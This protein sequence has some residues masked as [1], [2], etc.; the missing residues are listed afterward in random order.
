MPITK[1]TVDQL[2]LTVDPDTLG[3]ADTSELLHHPLSWIGQERAE[4]AVRFGLGMDQADYNLFVLGEAGSGR[5]SLL[6]QAMQVAASNRATPPDLC[7]LYNFDAPERPRALRLPSGQGRLL[8]QHMARMMNTLLADIPQQLDGPHF[9]V[10]SER[11]AKSYKEEESRAYAELDAFGEAR[12][13]TMHRESGHLLFTLRGREGHAMTEDEMLA[14]PKEQRAE[15]DRAEQELI[16]EINRYMELTRPLERVMVDSLASL[17]RKEVKPLL[18][19]EL[20]RIRTALNK[21]NQDSARLDTYLHQVKDDIL[22]NLELFKAAE[23]DDELRKEMLNKLLTRYRINLVVDNDG[24][25]GA[26][27]IVEDNPLFRSLFGSIEY[28]SEN[29]VLVTDFSRIR[30]GSLHRADGGFLMLHLRDLLADGL[31]WEKLRRFLRSGRLQIEEPGTAFAPIAA[32][33]L[34]PEA[35]DVD[36]KIILIG[37]RDLYYEL[38][39]GDPEFARRFRVKVDFAERFAASDATRRASA[40]FVAHT[41]KLLGLPHFS[42]AAVSRLLEQGH[43]EAEDKS[44]Q[45]AIF[46]HTEALILESAALCQTRAG[47]LVAAVDVDMALAARRQRH[48]YPEQRLRES[49]AEGDVLIALQGESVGQLN[50]LTVV[51]LGDHRFGFPVRVSARTYAGEEGLINIEREV[52]MSGPIHDKGVLILHHY[53]AALFT[54]NAPL[55]FNASIVFEQEY[56]GVEGD[57]ASCAELYVL[58]SSLSGLPLRQGI[59]VTGALNQHGEV[60]PVGGINEKIEGFFDICAAAGLEGGQGVLIPDRN[61]RHLMLDHRVVEAVAQGRFHIHTIGHVIDGLE[62]LAGVPAGRV[63]VKGVY[64]RG[65][66]LGLAQSTLQ[67]YRRACLT[68]EHKRK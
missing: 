2:R 30:A 47:D 13:F 41:C 23:T 57:S 17:A 20:R 64:T 52:N 27:V 28:Q 43:R 4:T 38:Q 63:N 59:A 31:V 32:V 65:S 33:S 3:F 56:S 19:R 67:A 50:G 39:E 58:L 24:L 62:L 36:V 44:R 35:V 1:L 12:N 22:D 15:I 60:L 11:I 37:S 53:L 8:R 26:P 42:A 48:D 16:A 34:E 10:E 21:T 9:K 66:V 18:D 54:R 68:M 45:S 46:G 51:D 6:R 29:D 5:S 49:I 40:I 61:R 25:R 7:Y 14:L 55:A